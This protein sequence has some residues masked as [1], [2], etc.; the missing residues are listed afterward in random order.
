MSF[1]PV[2]YMQTDARWKNVKY[3]TPAESATIGGSGCGPTAAAMV[4]AEWADANET[5]VK[6]CDWS[7]ENGYKATGQGTYYS[8]FEPYFKKFGLVCERPNA[9]NLYHNPGAAAHLAAYNAVKR[10]DYVI[11]CMGVGRWTSSGHFILWYGIDGDNVLINDPNS[12]AENRTRASWS[13]FKNEVKYYFIIRKPTNLK[14]CGATVDYT[15]VDKDGYLNVRYG[16][17]TGYDVYGPSLSGTVIPVDK[18]VGSW[19]RFVQNGVRYYVNTSGLARGA[20]NTK[21]TTVDKAVDALVKKGVINTADYWK[22]CAGGIQYLDQLL[23]NMANANVGPTEKYGYTT[24]PEALFAMANAGVI[25]SP[26]YW[27]ENCGSLPH[28]DTLVIRFANMLK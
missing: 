24:V 8:F 18:V 4:V 20:V 27:I 3:A 26:G 15:V 25:N 17:G 13:F 28:L 9:A 5:P 11:A 21:I 19:A 22:G 10:G 14:A 7:M 16:A 2:S 1:K 6:A 23:I 12:T